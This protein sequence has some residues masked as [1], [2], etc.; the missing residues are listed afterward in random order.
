MTDPAGPEGRPEDGSG[1]PARRETPEQ[2]RRRLAAIFGDVLPD[3]TTDERDP[4]SGDT[5]ESAS[6]AWLRSQVPPHHGS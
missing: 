3:T 1:E 5:G 4:G 6:D 2:R